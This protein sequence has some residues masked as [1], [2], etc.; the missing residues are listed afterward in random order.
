MS[1]LSETSDLLLV[2]EEQTNRLGR[3]RLG[4][5]S[6]PTKVVES[7]VLASGV[8]HEKQKWIWRGTYSC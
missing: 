6:L 1:T 2:I 5:D 8:A 7:A 4:F 3:K